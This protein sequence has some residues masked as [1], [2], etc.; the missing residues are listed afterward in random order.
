MASKSKKA[1]LDQ[2]MGQLSA[3]MDGL[4]A[5][6]DV[7]VPTLPDEQSEMSRPIRSSVRLLNLPLSQ[8]RRNET[9]PRKHFDE[10]G[11]RALAESIRKDGLL[12]PIAVAKM[13]VEDYM[14]IDGERRWRAMN[15]IAEQ[16]LGDG[17]MFRPEA[18][19]CLV[20]LDGA[21]L[22][23]ANIE[24]C[25]FLANEL[26]EPL[27]DIERCLFLHRAVEHFGLEKDEVMQRLSVSRTAL[28]R[29][30]QVV[31]IAGEDLL[32][33]ISGLTISVRALDEVLH[34]AKTRGGGACVDACLNHIA[35]YVDD[36]RAL[37]PRET[38]RRIT[39]WLDEHYPAGSGNEEPS[40][41]EGKKRPAAN[42][43]NIETGKVG[44]IGWRAKKAGERVEVTITLPAHAW[45]GLKDAIHDWASAN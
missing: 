5:L 31:R 22:G 17:S 21:S 25:A 36:F 39:A 8:I 4:V 6:D 27:T 45:S 1:L 2:G 38:M 16:G 28:Y 11:L 43:Q 18:V 20:R 44:A 32:R 42:E 35:T 30:L 12:Q 24:V 33:A 3:M 26:S 23:E 10:Q 13:G 15:M 40:K 14:L 7:D 37:E 9:Q 34:D 41:G 19:P 29:Y